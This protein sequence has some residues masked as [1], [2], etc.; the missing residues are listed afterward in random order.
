MLTIFSQSF[1]IFKRRKPPKSVCSPH[2]TVTERCVSD[3]GFVPKFDL[4]QMP[5]I[6][7]LSTALITHNIQHLLRSNVHG[8][9]CKLTKLVLNQAVPNWIGLNRTMRST[10]KACITKSW[11]ICDLIRYYTVWNGNTTPTF[12]DNLSVPASWVKKSKREKTARQKLTNTIFN[13]G[14]SSII[15]FLNNTGVRSCSGSSFRQSSI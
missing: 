14:T 15:Q 2:V 4:L 8:Y 13:F 7:K 3:A 12:W 1:R 10:T 11:E 5:L 9:G 6:R